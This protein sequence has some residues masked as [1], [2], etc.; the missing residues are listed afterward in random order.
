L[1]FRSELIT[2]FFA[3]FAQRRCLNLILVSIVIIDLTR[4]HLPNRLPDR[5]PFLMDEQEFGVAG[6][7]CD[8]NPRFAMPN[9]PR[10]R[11]WASRRLHTIRHDFEIPIGEVTHARYCFALAAL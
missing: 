8:H 7:R 4:W 11:V 9:R 3:E 6:H 10:P 2:G 1:A 5:D